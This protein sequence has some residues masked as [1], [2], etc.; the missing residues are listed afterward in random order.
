IKTH[1]SWQVKQPYP[2]IYLWRDPHGSTY[3]VDHTG[4]RTLATTEPT[5]PAT[6][7][8]TIE[9]YPTGHE[10]A[11]TGWHHAHAA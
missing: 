1:G 5:N 11:L 9:M 4:T 2:G 3:L 6:A 7:D 8:L 10:V